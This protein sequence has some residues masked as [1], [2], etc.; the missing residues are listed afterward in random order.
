MVA[1]SIEHVIAKHA[2]EDAACEIYMKR[3][4]VERVAI[5]E[6]IVHSS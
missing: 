6:F 5:Y 1:C 4:N 3:L 2:K